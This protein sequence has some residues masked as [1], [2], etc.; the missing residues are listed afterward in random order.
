M[1]TVRRRYE[2]G[3]KVVKRREKMGKDGKD[4]LSLPV[5][6]ARVQ[7]FHMV[8]LPGGVVYSY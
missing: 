4:E 3:K 7:M 6:V 2:P 1:K 5:S 8:R